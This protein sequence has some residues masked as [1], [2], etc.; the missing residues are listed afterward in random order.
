MA[1]F[2]DDR[3][4]AETYVYGTEPS[5][6]LVSLRGRLKPGARCL[7]LADG[8]GRN[9]VWLAQQGLSV[10]SV[11]SSPVAQE[12]A[13]RLAA[14]RGISLDTRCA[15]LTCMNWP[16]ASFDVVVSVFLHLP[17]AVRRRV[18]QSVWRALRP[19]GLVVVQAFSPAQ[20]RFKS[21]GPTE[22]DLLYTGA[23]LREDFPEAR[24]VTLEECTCV[25]DEGPF[26]QGEA[27]VVNL[28]CERAAGPL[29]VNAE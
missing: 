10:V 24:I 18:H 8:E 23:L 15:D 12:K 6:F 25:L 26:H 3:Y 19:E 5:A 11:D 4:S 17:A 7:A 20:L 14:S 1:T 28:A 2:W 9:G 27:A 29:Q 22:L 21:G 16:D 13:R